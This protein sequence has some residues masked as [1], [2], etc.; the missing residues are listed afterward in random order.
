MVGHL[1]VRTG[2]ASAYGLSLALGNRKGLMN[3][4]ISRKTKTKQNKTNK[5]TE[6]TLC[7]L[8]LTAL[9]PGHVVFRC[10][11]LSIGEEFLFFVCVIN[12]IRSE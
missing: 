6:N 1:G 8:R 11:W 9:S 3:E 10:I 7:E 2:S 5:Q 4:D 12:V